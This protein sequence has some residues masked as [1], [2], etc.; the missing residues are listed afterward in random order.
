MNITLRLHLD[1]D[2]Q[3]LGVVDHRL[4]GVVAAHPVV[5]H[6]EHAHGHEVLGF[7]ELDVAFE[8][9]PVSE[10]DEAEEFAVD[11]SGRRC[12]IVRKISKT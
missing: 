9:L 12:E 10:L 11:S 2:L 8:D 1:D 6:A 4:G 3:L 7:D 5:D